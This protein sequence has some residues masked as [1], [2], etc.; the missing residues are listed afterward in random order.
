MWLT[1]HRDCEK[2]SLWLVSS[3]KRDISLRL[4][5]RMDVLLGD[6]PAC[7]LSVMMSS[8]DNLASDIVAAVLVCVSEPDAYVSG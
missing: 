4:S 7:R 8:A 3:N 5:A 6:W 2:G 1:A